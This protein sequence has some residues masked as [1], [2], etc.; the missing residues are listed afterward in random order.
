MALDQFFISA[1]V[2]AGAIFAF[3]GFVAYLESPTRRRYRDRTRAFE[4]RTDDVD[5]LGAPTRRSPDK[6]GL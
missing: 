1:F 4:I 6:A 2:I 5:E 3:F